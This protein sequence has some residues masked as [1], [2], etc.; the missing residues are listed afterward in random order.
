MPPFREPMLLPFCGMALGVVAERLWGA[1]RWESA[2]AAG[3]LFLLG[4]FA[5]QFALPRWRRICVLLASIALGAF[6]AVARAPG[7][8]PI[9]DA[10]PN[11]LVTLS[12]C[13]VEPPRR[14]EDRDQWI[15]ELAPRA[16]IRVTVYHDPK[17]PRH[18]ALPYG[19]RVEF[20]GR[21]RSP[22]NFRNEGA[23]DIEA[24]WADRQI[25]WTV[26]TRQLIPQ[27]GQ[28]GSTF[29]ATL[30]Q[31]RGWLLRR[32]DLYFGEQAP[33][34]A[35]LLLGESANLDR[36]WTDRFRETGT[37]HALVVS[38]THVAA[39]AGGL[40]LLMRGLMIPRLPA[41]FATSALVWAY[42]LLAGGTAP[43]VRAA[44]GF[45]LYSICGFLYRRARLLNLLAVVGIG[46]LVVDPRQLFHA[47]FQLSFGALAA[48]VALALPLADRW[49]RPW[50]VAAG[51]LRNRRADVG[52]EPAVASLRV[53]LRLIAETVSWCLRCPAAWAERGIAI[54]VKVCAFVANIGLASAA[55]QLALTLAFVAYFHRFAFTAVLA[56]VG[57][58]SSVEPAILTGFAAVL[59]GL[60]PLIWA[61]RFLLNTAA[62]IADLHVAWEPHWRMPDPPLALAL[63]GMAALVWVAWSLRVRSRWLPFSFAAASV[64]GALLV[65]HPFPVE[66]RAGR[67]ELTAID[68]GQGDAL[69][70]A[71]PDGQRLLVDGGGFPSI[72][73]RKSPFDTG[74]QVVAPYLWSRGIRSLD[75]VCLTHGHA[76]HMN[77]LPAILE[78]FRPRELWISGRGESRELDALYQRARSLGVR[79]RVQRKGDSFHL[80]G[81]HFR[82]VGPDPVASAEGPPRNN[83]SVALLLEFGRHRFLLPGDVERSV[84]ESLVY[85]GL[86]RIDVLKVA[87][88]GGR[89]STTQALL[90]AAR[91]AVAV[92]SAGADNRYGH[93]HAEVLKRL[94]DIHAATMRTDRDG[95]ITVL[96]DG[97]RLALDTFRWS[98]AAGR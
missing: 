51:N 35:A 1:D 17:L 29:S 38:G 4:W 81:V 36:A 82:V 16:R 62:A 52:L 54:L 70:V 28:C 20:A 79:V 41:L 42:A 71:L 93:P 96:S 77:G 9:L 83:D 66:A 65:A 44:A 8:R 21:P 58:V 72:R 85:E 55:V 40:V 78:S 97:Q 26:S 68:V 12:G 49:I 48:L 63:A 46:F 3:F 45:T 23:F 25:F 61:T 89:T 6:L 76:D 24:Y 94:D 39:L 31:V 57:V 2:L 91:P 50:Q 5:E 98:R 14:F 10:Q 15:V 88:H 64:C 56:N 30:Y 37:Y 69:F 73:G 53:E 27:P 19:T 32:I 18:P 75:I 43:V 90:E 87:H 11:E 59:T 33:Q 80:G 74:E 22:R 86:G 47:D 95:R 34:A 84:E 67:L 92:I 60:P 13:I 7:P